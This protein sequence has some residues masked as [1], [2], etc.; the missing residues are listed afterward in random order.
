[1]NGRFAPVYRGEGRGR[2][3]ALIRTL[4]YLCDSVDHIRCLTDLSAKHKH[5]FSTARWYPCHQ[6]RAG[7]R[8]QPSVIALMTASSRVSRVRACLSFVSP[9]IMSFVSTVTPRPLCCS[10]K[11]DRQHPCQLVVSDVSGPEGPRL[12]YILQRWLQLVLTIRS[13]PHSTAIV[14]ERHMQLPK[15]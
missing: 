1:M 13:T 8:L 12:L 10:S 4:A 9:A 11:R 2:D 3:E 7:F 15:P 5:N 14:P 6:G